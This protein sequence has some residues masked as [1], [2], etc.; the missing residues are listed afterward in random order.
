MRT[1]RISTAITQEALCPWTIRAVKA[2]DRDFSYRFRSPSRRRRGDEAT[3][4]PLAGEAD[5]KK[6]QP[7]NDLLCRECLHVITSLAE[8]IAVGGSHRHTFANPQG[9]LFE[10]GCFRS[11]PG[12]G[13]IG[14]ATDEWSWFSGF[15]WKIAVCAA[16]STH[17]GWLYLSGG[18]DTFHGLILNRLISPQEWS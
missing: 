8:S 14:P 16:C 12:C 17:L 11:A 3:S 15:Q 6:P 2:S 1:T 4:Q 7:E 18:G 9:I 13:Y 5:D 10:I